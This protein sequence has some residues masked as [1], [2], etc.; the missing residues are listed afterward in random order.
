MNSSQIKKHTG[1]GLSVS[2]HQER[3]NLPWFFLRLVRGNRTSWLRKEQEDMVNQG[4]WQPYL[5]TCYCPVFMDQEQPK[6]ACFLAFPTN[7]KA[8]FFCL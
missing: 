8:I 6:K 2:S 3:M 7:A 1:D 4:K 5:T